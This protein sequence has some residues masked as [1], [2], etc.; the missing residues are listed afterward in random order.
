M[1][2]PRL[3]FG[4]LVESRYLEQLQPSGLISALQAR[5]HDVT[6]SDPDNVPCVASGQPW[7]DGVDVVVARGRSLALLCL[8][9]S[10]EIAGLQ[11]INRRAAIGG[12][13]NKAEMAL[14]LE[15]NNVP[16][17]RTYYGSIECLADIIPRYPIVLKPVF[18]DN[19]EG[20]RVVHTGEEFMKL[21]WNEPVALAQEYIAN[22]GYDLKLY[23]IG[24][25]VWAVR[26]PS[27]LTGL[28][29]TSMH[30]QN[31]H[32]REAEML[33]PSQELIDLGRRCGELFGLELYGVDCLLTP[34]GPTVIEV[35]DFPNYSA[36]S[37]ASEML[38]DHVVWLAGRELWI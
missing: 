24:S 20:L 26:K 23:G 3:H 22:D 15:A 10:A 1:R 21:E 14:T 27:P 25:E 30:S 2:T 16:T 11:T 12:V 6:V 8:L 19:A 7:L 4:L 13:L 33:T 34:N 38:A 28:G 17:P 5:G 35:N 37:D 9:A 36:L 32:G 18:G 31:R 29:C